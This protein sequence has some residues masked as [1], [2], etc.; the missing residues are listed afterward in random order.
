MDF[1]GGLDGE[2]PDCNVGDLGSFPGWGRSPGEENCE[3]IQNSCLENS[4]DRGAW[5]APVHGVAESQKEL[6]NENTYTQRTFKIN[7]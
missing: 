3:I 5:Q 2:V 1:P 7:K 6:R 4:K